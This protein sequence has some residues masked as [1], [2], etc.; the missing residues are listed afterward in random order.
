MSERQVEDVDLKIGADVG[1]NSFKVTANILDKNRKRK[2]ASA[3][4]TSQPKK[5]KTDD[6]YLDSGVKKTMIIAIAENVP[7]TWENIKTFRD[8]LK[9]NAFDFLPAHDFSYLSKALGHQGFSCTWPCI[10]CLA[11]KPLNEKGEPRTLGHCKVLIK[12]I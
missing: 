2:S 6:K 9:L 11:R 10:Y 7:E 5:S 12:I 4:E 1:H 3:T 8:I